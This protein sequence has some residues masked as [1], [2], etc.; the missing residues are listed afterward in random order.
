MPVISMFYGVVII[1]ADW[2]VAIKGEL[3]FPIEPLR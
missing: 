3:P 1:M 2:K